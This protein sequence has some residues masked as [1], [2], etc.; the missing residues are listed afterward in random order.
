MAPTHRPIG[1]TYSRVS[2]PNDKREASL[3]TQE[4]AQV[5]LLESRGYDV[6]REFRFRERYTGMESI[7]DRPVLNHIRDLIASGRVQAM[8]AYDTDR[9]ARD[10]RHLLTVVA[11]NH[12][13]NVETVFVKCDHDTQGRIGEMILYM[14]G[15]A[16]ALEFDAILDRTARGRMKILQKGQWVGGS[17]CK[18]GYSWHKEERRRTANPET[19]PVVRRIF[20]EVAS[21]VSVNKLADDLTAEG[22]PTPFVYAGRMKGETR[23]WATVVRKIIRDRVYLGEVRAGRY[24]ATGAKLANGRRQMKLRPENEHIKL[25]DG[26]TAALVTS[27]LYD[28]ANMMMKRL[29][30]RGG[31]PATNKL[32][33]LTGAIYCGAC[34]SRMTPVSHVNW[35]RHRTAK[36]KRIR[37]YR[38]FARRLKG[39]PDCKEV[40]GAEWV[41]AEAWKE[42]EKKVLQPGFLEREMSKL[43]KDD[44]SSRVRSDL[45]AAEVRRRKIDKQVKQLVDCQLENAG[46]KLLAT[47]LKEKLQ[48]LDKEAEELDYHIADLRM[49]IEALGHR[50]KTI[51]AFL[52]GIDELRDRARMGHLD[53]EEK[54]TILKAMDARVFAW[55]DG[56]FRKVKVELPFGTRCGKLESTP[57]SST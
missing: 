22:V 29:N 44:G 7:Y 49:R 54:R 16:S 8:S 57:G 46:S 1:L 32:H 9:L 34:K 50:G 2:N 21:G 33:L 17:T 31:R 51:A 39:G 56:D 42:I 28:R 38:C 53:M 25:E 12:K 13:H 6:P 41:E 14:K 3:D 45:K 23:W 24:V 52:A 27:E 40:C 36:K 48:G 30:T 18:Y 20:E 35:N 26:R 10:P 19:A 43:A 55:K 11:D 4:D 15:F 5:A 47:A 37:A